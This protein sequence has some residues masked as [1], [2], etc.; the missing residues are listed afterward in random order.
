[1]QATKLSGHAPPRHKYVPQAEHTHTHTPTFK[2]RVRCINVSGVHLA[3]TNI[4]DW[5][6]MHGAGNNKKGISLNFASYLLPAVKAHLGYA[7]SVCPHSPSLPHAASASSKNLPQVV[8]ISVSPAHAQSPSACFKQLSV[9]V[10]S[11]NTNTKGRS[12]GHW[13][14]PSA[15]ACRR[16]AN[17]HF[18]L[19]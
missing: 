16:Q 3:T 15:L 8:A 4:F 1:M 11:T 6:I 18:A 13:S 7:L 19:W 2:Y 17:Q 5:W 9:L 14:T 12:S 10:S